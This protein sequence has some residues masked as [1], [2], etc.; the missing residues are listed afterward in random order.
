MWLWNDV[1]YGCYYP[2]LT[3]G[4]AMEE[5]VHGGDF[6]PHKACPDCSVTANWHHFKKIP[7]VDKSRIL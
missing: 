2:H 3:G 7:R 4:R 5:F 1:Y 6:C